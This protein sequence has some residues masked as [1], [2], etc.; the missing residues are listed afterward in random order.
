MVKLVA[1][2]LVSLTAVASAEALQPDEYVEA[3][4]EPNP[5]FNMFG[6]RFS[7]GALPIDG[8][9]TVV[10]S[11]GLGVEHPVFKKTRVFGDYEWLWLSR[12]D[13]RDIN[14]VVP[15][16]E[17]HGNGHR[18]SLG[19]RRELVG[20]RLGS[21]VRMFIDGEVGANV[22]LVN[23]NMTGVAFLP[24]AL[25]GLRFGYDVYSRS[26]SSP[27]RTFEAE[28]LVRAI[29]IQHGA[30]ALLGVGMFWGN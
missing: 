9:H 24:G 6:F 7:A 16:P 29:A 21:T 14:S 28:V 19:L 18:T 20:K 22:A 8:S 10:L 17:R 27:S 5:A 4:P 12:V 2:V 25:G 3:E 15:R 1:L 26:D 23:D 13:E 11:V 30:G